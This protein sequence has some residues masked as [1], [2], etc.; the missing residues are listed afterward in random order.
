MDP[1]EQS[2]R[3][4]LKNGEFKGKEYL[5]LFRPVGSTQAVIEIGGM[6]FTVDDSTRPKYAGMNLNVYKSKRRSQLPELKTQKDVMEYFNSFPKLGKE[7]F[8]VVDIPHVPRNYGN[9]KVPS[10]NGDSI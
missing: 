7:D 1:K 10:F 4:R 6:K 8:I 9:Q 3:E 2:I 5:V